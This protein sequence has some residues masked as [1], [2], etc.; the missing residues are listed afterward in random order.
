M[1]ENPLT[2]DLMARRLERFF[3]AHRDVMPCKYLRLVLDEAGLPVGS[4]RR[5]LMPDRVQPHGQA[6]DP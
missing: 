3:G 6:P 2:R 1:N 4:S 5:E